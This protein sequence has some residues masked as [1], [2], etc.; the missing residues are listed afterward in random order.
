M[1]PGSYASG[2]CALSD[3]FICLPHRWE[4][5]VDLQPSHEQE[6]LRKNAERFLSEEYRHSDGSSGDDSDD[7]VRR[8]KIWNQF[9]SLGWL[10]LP[11]PVEFG[12]SGGDCV[13]LAVLMEAFGSHLVTEPYLPTVVLGGG[14]IA[15]IASPVQR[16]DLLNGLIEGQILLAFAYEDRSTTTTARRS[17]QGYIIEGGKKVV[18]GAH[19]ADVLLVSARLA[20]GGLGVFVVPK[21]TNGLA[22]RAYDTVA[23]ADAGDVDLSGVAVQASA[24]LGGNENAGAIIDATILR[25]I[26]ALSADALGALAKIVAS[27]VEYA[28][29]RAQFGQPIGKFQA[30]QH[31]LVDMKIKEEEARASALFATLSLDSSPETRAR[32]VFGAKAKIGRSARYIYQNAIQVHGAIGT[33]N[34]L[35]LGRYAK[36]LIA[37]EILFASTRE[38]L[39]RYANLISQPRVASTGLLY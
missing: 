36:R 7:S 12:G 10:G 30:I 14:L 26:A 35:S 32:A 5:A 4:I 34:E 29:T 11:F 28:K 19:S 25:A 2:R 27:S 22:V 3:L 16:Q 21:R 39:R 38:S 13:D 6:I 8:T 9:A 24:L 18:L 37:Y 1:A 31:R 23:G 20:D 15:S 33:T 17:S